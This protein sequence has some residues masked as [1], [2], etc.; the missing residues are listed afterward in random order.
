LLYLQLSKVKF[1]GHNTESFVKFYLGN[2][3][4]FTVVWKP[5][6]KY[7]YEYQIFI[8]LRRKDIFDV[9]AHLSPVV[10]PAAELHLAVLVVEGEPGDVDLAG[11]LEDA[12]WYVGAATLTRQHHVCRVRAV[13][14]FVR[15]VKEKF[16]YENLSEVDVNFIMTSLTVYYSIL[17]VLLIL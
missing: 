11:G 15:T 9:A 5:K 8:C 6:V 14:C 1:C 3:Y 17:E 13:K 10:G 16:V 12:G 4:L 2:Q 7:E